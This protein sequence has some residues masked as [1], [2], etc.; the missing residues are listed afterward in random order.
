MDASGVAHAVPHGM[1]RQ[2]VARSFGPGHPCIAAVQSG[3]PRHPGRGT[4]P[5][6]ETSTCSS[7]DPA[8]ASPCGRCS[9]TD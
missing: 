3:N 4:P 8:F 7:A 5:A 9:P 2:P 1:C 6:A